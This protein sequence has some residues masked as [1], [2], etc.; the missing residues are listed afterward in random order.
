ML[1]A[2]RAGKPPR[3]GGASSWPACG[4]HACLTHCPRGSRAEKAVPAFVGLRAGE[5]WPGACGMPAGHS[6]EGTASA[7]CLGTRSPGLTVCLVSHILPSGCACRTRALCCCL[8][9]S[10]FPAWAEPLDMLDLVANNFNP[11]KETTFRV[12]CEALTA[13]LHLFH[14]SLKTCREVSVSDGRS[15]RPLDWQMSLSA[16]S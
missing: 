4:S 10:I 14:L 5:L 9:E 7:R 13:W 16:G 15:A 12:F 3:L 8:H 1:E 6:S 2:A 11:L